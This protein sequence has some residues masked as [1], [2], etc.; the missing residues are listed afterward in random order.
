MSRSFKPRLNDGAFRAV[1]VTPK[2]GEVR[3]ALPR[4]FRQFSVVGSSFPLVVSDNEAR[5]NLK[6]VK[7]CRDTA[8]FAL[9][10]LATFAGICLRSRGIATVLQPR[11][12][13]CRRR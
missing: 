12:K 13:I 3:S 2:G 9:V 8:G 7:K 5:L 4:R 1:S 10:L 6:R 11:R